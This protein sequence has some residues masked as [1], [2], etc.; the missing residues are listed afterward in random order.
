MDDEGSESDQDEEG[1]LLRDRGT[2]SAA[3]DEDEYCV[4]SSPTA[5]YL[6]IRPSL[7]HSLLGA[8]AVQ[9]RLG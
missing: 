3:F 7:V 2:A 1:T 8:S 9:L 5:S 6:H 4:R